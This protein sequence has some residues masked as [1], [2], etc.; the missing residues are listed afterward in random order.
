MKNSRVILTESGGV[1][2]GAFFFRMPCVT[3][4]EGAE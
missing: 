3:L 2:K 4:R 1:Q